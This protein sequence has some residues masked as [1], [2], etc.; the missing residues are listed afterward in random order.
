MSFINLQTIICKSWASPMYVW[1][2]KYISS[3]VQNF[4]LVSGKWSFRFKVNF[5]IVFKTGLLSF[6]AGRIQ[7]YSESVIRRF[8]CLIKYINQRVFYLLLQIRL[9]L[10]GHI[11]RINQRIEDKFLKNQD[12]YEESR[13]QQL[14]QHEN[15]MTKRKYVVNFRY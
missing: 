2:K 7:F 12:C 8:Y 4:P 10:F 15:H 1:Y 6:S 14:P 13:C 3:G 5:T 9:L 11:T